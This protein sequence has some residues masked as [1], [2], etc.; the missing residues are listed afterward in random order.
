MGDFSTRRDP[1]LTA[2][3]NEQVS[4][5]GEGRSEADDERDARIAAPASGMRETLATDLGHPSAA[6]ATY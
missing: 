6:T 1:I 3:A 5:G 4:G 2:V